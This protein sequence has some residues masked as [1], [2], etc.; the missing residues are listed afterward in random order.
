MQPF[1]MFVIRAGDIWNAIGMQ[2]LDCSP[3]EVFDEITW[4]GECQHTLVEYGRYMEILLAY[5][6]HHGLGDELLSLRYV[7]GTNFHLP[8]SM[9]RPD[10]IL[11]DFG[12]QEPESTSGGVNDHYFRTVHG[13][14]ST[15]FEGSEIGEDNEGQLVVYT[16]VYNENS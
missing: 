2:H 16:G 10:F 5:I 1:A 14:A 9:R 8:E 15:F 4:G 7:E 3:E 12:P 11:M 13:I 6:R